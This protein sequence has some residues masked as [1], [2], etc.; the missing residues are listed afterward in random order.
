VIT[1]SAAVL[2]V[3]AV[4][5]ALPMKQDHGLGQRLRVPFSRVAANLLNNVL[6]ASVAPEQETGFSRGWASAPFLGV[7][8]ADGDVE[9]LFYG[10]GADR[11][12]LAFCE[13]IG[14]TEAGADPRFATYGGRTQHA[15]ALRTAL[16]SHT[17]HIE[18]QVLLDTLWDCGAMAVPRWGVDEAI[19]SEQARANGL[20]AARTSADAPWL[21][22]SPW[23]VDGR[24]ADL[25]SV[26]TIGADTAAFLSTG[27]AR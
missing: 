22:T 8:A 13:R 19:A 24:R 10:P 9:M 27:A 15:G 6:T 17:V 21:Q 18:R 20:A 3:Q 5:A 23:E 12:W 25:R 11:G 14:A 16:G 2:G 7:P 4:L 26:P 1:Y